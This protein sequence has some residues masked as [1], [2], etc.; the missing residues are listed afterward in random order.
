MSDVN[1]YFV[2]HGQ[3]YMNNAEN[4]K[5]WLLWWGIPRRV[6]FDFN[7]YTSPALNTL[8][9]KG[10]RQMKRAAS[11]LHEH[12][13]E[14][15]I[16]CSTDERAV[17]SAGY[18]SQLY[19]FREEQ[20]AFLCEQRRNYWT[21]YASELHSNALARF[22]AG[23]E[24]L[25]MNGTFIIVSH[26]IVMA[27]TLGLEHIDNGEIVHVRYDGNFKVLRKFRP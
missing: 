25:L 14:P 10:K 23:L 1:V 15:V 2:R 27:D 16:A 26:L 18:I 21:G 7:P 19:K 24:G 22:K 17:Q 11:W 5:G 13:T 4:R 6:G 12:V 9:R 8:T 20:Y 3:T